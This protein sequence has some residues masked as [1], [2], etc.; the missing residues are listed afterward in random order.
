MRVDQVSMAVYGSIDYTQQ[1]IRLNPQTATRPILPAGMTLTLPD[2][3]T[4]K[5]KGVTLWG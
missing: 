3:K 1:I 2:K 4:P 5:P